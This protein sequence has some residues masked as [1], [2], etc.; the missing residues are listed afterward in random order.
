MEQMETTS[1]PSETVKPAENLV[2]FIVAFQKDQHQL[3]FPLDETLSNLRQE[4]AKKTG[5]QAGLQK[6]MYKGSETRPLSKKKKKLWTL[7]FVSSSSF[8]FFISG[9]LKDDSKTLRELG[10]KDGVK[11]MLV[12]S[13]ITD[14]MSAA[15]A[16]SPSATSSAKEGFVFDFVFF[17]FLCFSSFCTIPLT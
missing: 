17:L 2:K 9:L 11:V 8:F 10:F 15:T 4:I 6:L 14:V 13:S 3:E 16:P 7:L 1:N 12:G 5:I